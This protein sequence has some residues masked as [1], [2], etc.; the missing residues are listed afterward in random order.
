MKSCRHKETRWNR[1][2]PRKSGVRFFDVW[3]QV[4][5]LHM[6]STR[7]KSCR[8]KGKRAGLEPQRGH[9][10]MQ[11]SCT[12]HRASQKDEGGLPGHRSEQSGRLGERGSPSSLTISPSRPANAGVRGARPAR[13]QR[14]V[15]RRTP[16]E[17]L[18]GA[19]SRTTDSSASP[20]ARNLPS[21][22]RYLA[23]SPSPN[24]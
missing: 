17:R 12:V 13:F 5:N 18:P 9:R 8:H 2:T 6:P 7:W 10:A 19:V 20:V 11:S 3:V 1:V 15:D 14:A 24:R 23:P 16:D 22:F 21:S 4:F